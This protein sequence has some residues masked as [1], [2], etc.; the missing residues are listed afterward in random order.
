MPPFGGRKQ[1]DP[2]S[3]SMGLQHPSHLLTRFHILRLMFTCRITSL[4]KRYPGQS[5]NDGNYDGR[6]ERFLE[7]WLK[8]NVQI[9]GTTPSRW[10]PKGSK[11][12]G[13]RKGQIIS[14]VGSTGRA[15]GRICISS[16]TKDQQY[17]DPLSVDFPAE[18]L[19]EPTLQ[20]VFDNQKHIF[21][22]ELR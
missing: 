4:P 13:Y 11:Q 21:H 7:N 19:I 1:P 15:T 6:L 8:S 22:V 3:D 14:Y 16:F 5:V 2:F 17:I 9:H 20:T 12:H 18:D 10:L